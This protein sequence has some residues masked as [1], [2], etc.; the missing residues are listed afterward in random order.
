MVSLFCLFQGVGGWMPVAWRIQSVFAEI[1][2]WQEHMSVSP[3]PSEPSLASYVVTYGRRYWGLR[4]LTILYLLHLTL[5]PDHWLARNVG[6]LKMPVVA[7]VFGYLTR[8]GWPV[9]S[10]T[11]WVVVPPILPLRRGWYPWSGLVE[12]NER[13]CWIQRWLV[14]IVMSYLKNIFGINNKRFKY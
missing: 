3:T 7:Q 12:F 10:L 6:C 9:G 2:R 8:V 4:T 11:C 14:S 1:P 5:A 13:E